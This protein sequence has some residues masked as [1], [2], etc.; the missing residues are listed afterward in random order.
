VYYINLVNTRGNGSQA[1]AVSAQADKQGYYGVQ[2]HGFQ[3]T[4]LANEGAQVY[5]KCL[6][7]GSTDFIFGQ[8]AKAWFDGSDIRVVANSIGYI[9]AN[10]RDSESNPS[11]YVI[12]KSTVAAASG[13]TV[14]AGA[15][16]LGRPWRNYSRV[17]F[18]AT[19]MSNVINTAG[20]IQWGSSEARTE[21]VYYGEYAN[22]GDGS[23]GTRASFSKKLASPVDIETILGSAYK[24]WVD[25]SYLS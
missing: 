20:W 15:Y 9:T 7:V 16:Y 11:F 1:L 19:S 4:I 10:G 18:Q 23:K 14:K 12:N 21:H 17:V 22:T 25:T 5:A 6:I 13:N 3:D 8:R 2:F 24:D